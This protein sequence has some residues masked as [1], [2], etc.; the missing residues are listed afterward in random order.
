[1]GCFLITRNI[2]LFTFSSLYLQKSF[3]HTL[4]IT[5]RN[6]LFFKPSAGYSYSVSLKKCVRPWEVEQTLSG[7]TWKSL[8][9]DKKIFSKATLSFSGNTISAK[10]CNSIGGNYTTSEGKISTPALMSTKMY[11]DNISG[12]AENKFNLDNAAYRITGNGKILKIQTASGS[13]FTWRKVK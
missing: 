11:C 6:T 4:L 8:T 2:F 9:F 1:M 13:I 5:V 7:T 10:M 12:K 3:T